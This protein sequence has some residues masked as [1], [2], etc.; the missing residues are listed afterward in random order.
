M[1]ESAYPV[2]DPRHATTSERPAAAPL[3]HASV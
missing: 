2:Q 1:L 3:V